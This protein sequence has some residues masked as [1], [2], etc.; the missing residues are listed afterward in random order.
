LGLKEKALAHAH[1]STVARLRP[2]NKLRIKALLPEG[3]G[4][5]R[6][7]STAFRPIRSY[8]ILPNA[9]ALVSISLSESRLAEHSP[10]R[11]EPMKSVEFALL[12][13]EL[14]GSLDNDR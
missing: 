10:A 14:F 7:G 12:E 1:L 4:Y 13:S 5:W 11:F 9:T 8:E 6:A 3:H 2:K